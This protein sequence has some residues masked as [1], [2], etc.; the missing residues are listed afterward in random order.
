MLPE[1]YFFL[2]ILFSGATVFW[3]SVLSSNR[4]QVLVLHWLMA[5]L[6]AVK[7]GSLLAHAMQSNFKK[8]TQLS[9]DSK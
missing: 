7:A 5:A 2:F 9:L 6:V 4:K 1:A 8:M 3:I